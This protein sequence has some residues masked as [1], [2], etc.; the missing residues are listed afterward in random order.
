MQVPFKVRYSHSCGRTVKSQVFT[1]PAGN[2]D[3]DRPQYTVQTLFEDKGRSA[4]LNPGRGLTVAP[5]ENG[6]YITHAGMLGLKMPKDSP[7]GGR[8]GLGEGV[9]VVVRVAVTEDDADGVA[10]EER[11][12]DTVPVGERDADVVADT[13]ADDDGVTVEEAEADAVRDPDADTVAVK[14]AD[15]VAVADADPV[16]DRDVDGEALSEVWKKVGITSPS[17]TVL[18]DGKATHAAVMFKATPTSRAQVS[19]VTHTSSGDRGRAV[20]PV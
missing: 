6:L 11:E 16:A 15:G 20:S 3:R 19:F 17:A 9:P 12:A 13:E 7:T 18:L 14:D 4:W 2:S 8:T 5:P 10:V 1:S